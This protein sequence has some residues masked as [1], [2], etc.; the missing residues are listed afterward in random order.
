MGA[1]ESTHRLTISNDSI[2]VRDILLYRRRYTLLLIQITPAALQK[3][4]ES[5]KP[6]TPEKAPEVPVKRSDTDEVSYL[7]EFLL[8]P[9]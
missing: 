8:I 3:A 4:R 2:M 9:I 5:V 7:L 6:E 1:Q